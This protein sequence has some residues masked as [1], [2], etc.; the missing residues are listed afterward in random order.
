MEE[1]LPI[2]IAV[3]AIIISAASRKKKVQEDTPE[4]TSDSPWGGWGDLIGD[5]WERAEDPF[6]RAE[7]EAEEKKASQLVP[8]A[9]AKEHTSPIGIT[10]EEGLPQTFSYDELRRKSE[11]QTRA[12]KKSASEKARKE[13]GNDAVKSVDEEGGIF[14]EGFDPRMAVIYAEIMRPKFKEF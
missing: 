14:E 10:T 6:V 8:P 4:E 1:L 2:I 3:V 7:K 13:Y 5:A 11:E 12:A 9:E